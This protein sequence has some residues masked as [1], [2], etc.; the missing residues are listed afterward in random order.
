MS[1]ASFTQGLPSIGKPTA[2]LRC[3]SLAFALQ[4]MASHIWRRVAALAYLRRSHTE[5]DPPS[6]TAKLDERR[7]VDVTM[8][9]G[10]EW[11]KQMGRNLL[12]V[13][14]GF[15][16]GKRVLDPRPDPL[17]TKEFRQMLRGAGVEPLL[18]PAREVRT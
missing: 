18:L 13:E 4:P 6:N 7:S 14:T 9:P 1:A 11:M 3:H 10:G 5:S 16:R 8:S 15:V 2:S 12:D 17:Y